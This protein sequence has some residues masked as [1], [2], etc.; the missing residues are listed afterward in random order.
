MTGFR[1]VAAAALAV[2][3]ALGAVPNAGA[4][5]PAGPPADAMLLNVDEVRGIVGGNAD[6]AP[7][8]R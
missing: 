8:D 3:A 7:A 6:L 4:E 2:G 1:F 5:P